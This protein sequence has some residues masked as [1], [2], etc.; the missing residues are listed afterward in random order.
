MKNYFINSFVQNHFAT[1]RYTI[2]VENEHSETVN[3]TFVLPIPK[4]TFIANFSAIIDGV[5]YAGEMVLNENIST[6]DNGTNTQNALTA[7]VRKRLIDDPKRNIF[8]IDLTLAADKETTFIVTYYE[9]LIRKGSHYKQRLIVEPGQLVDTLLVNAIFLEDQGFE[10]FSYMLPMANDFHDASSDLASLLE[11]PTKRSLLYQLS[12]D[13]QLAASNQGVAGEVII[14]YDL[15]YTQGAGMVDVKDEYFVHYFTPSGLKPIDKNILFVLD[16]SGSMA[17]IKIQ[18]LRESMLTILDNLNPDDNF[19]ILRFESNTS[20]LFDY[21]VEAN[22]TNIEE[23]MILVRD[24]IKAGGGTAINDALLEAIISLKALPNKSRR[25]QLIFFLTDGGATVGV[26]SR[27]KILQNVKSEND[28]SIS[29]YCLGFGIN[30]D[31]KFLKELT[32]E[33]RG[34]YAKIP[35]DT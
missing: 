6:E 35:E 33:N 19:N 25:A 28:G 24:T 31:D 4:D 30:S 20:T 13:Q 32:K 34:I 27:K 12:R 18:Q 2:H 26:T 1:V 17:G 29:I 16:T 15:N 5:E 3:S 10:T 23:A 22:L 14:T 11:T 21:P 7:Q 9:Q 8:E